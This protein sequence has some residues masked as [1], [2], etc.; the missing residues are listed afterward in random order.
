MDDNKIHPEDLMARDGIKLSDKEIEGVGDVYNNYYNWRSYRS[1]LIKHFQ[2]YSFEEY[3]IISREL[4]W[5]SI[6]TQSDDLSSLGLDFSLPFARK[7]V[8][9]FLGRINSLGIKPEIVGDAVDALGTKML[10]AIYKKWR[11][12]SNDKV[13]NFWEL[14]YGIVNGTVCSYIGYNNEEKQQR[15]L[16]S[17]DPESGNFSI[18]KKKIKK[19]EVF[20]EIIPI[21][22]IY[23]PKIF[24]RNIQ[25]QGRNIWKKQMDVSDFKEEFGKYP[26]SK[27]VFP[28]SRIAEDSLYFR[29]LGGTGTISA[30]KIEVIREFDWQKD[31]FKIT[32][33]GIVLNKLGKGEKFEWSPM[34]FSHKMAPFTWGIMGPL[35]E[36]LAYGL[37]TPFLIK[38]PHK[39]LNVS[40]SMMV[41]QEL[42][43]IDPPTLTS[44]IESPE[45]IFG[46]HKVIQVNDVNA[47]KVMESKEPSNQFFTMQNS[48]Q[49]LMSA[50]AQGG[51]A[52]TIPSRQPK[53]AREV[54]DI[55]QMKQ[56]AMA[57][58][59]TMYY[60][61]LRQRIMLVLKTSLQ[62]MS[63]AKFQTTD[64]RV[65]KDILVPDMPLT[66]G[67]TGNMRIRLVK[68]GSKQ[69]DMSLFI[70]AIKES[71]KN[72]K[73]T[74]IVEVPIEFIENLDFVI[75]RIDL[76]PEDS[77]DLEI[78]NFVANVLTPMIQTYIPAGVADIGKT[79]LRHM[80]KLGENPADYAKDQSAQS[81]PPQ[82]NNPF[83]Q[84]PGGQQGVPAV[85]GN[86][87]QSTTGIKFGSQN[88]QPLAAQ[89]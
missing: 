22:D 11:S 59:V 54:S 65:Y 16:N 20:K 33:S 50:H 39:I 62:F 47:Y 14:L 3:L 75:N 9:D 85:Q 80:E 64:K 67:G 71:A 82:Q 32:A 69:P 30:N 73:P 35:D 61:I 12:T 89:Q 68:N 21:E 60:D 78:A 63:S 31:T 26:L 58:A 83:Q 8:L 41:E 70:E 7:E 79:F 5:N 43:A 87:Q 74:E 10:Q 36:K 76:E 45:L 57:N 23:L 56:Q 24:E 55:N 1:G 28:G 42:R 19:D 17:Y 25:K 66:D 27:Y 86:M 48:L 2:N 53:S 29:L 84:Q 44:D 46:Q 18:I 34:P 72:G 77:S 81:A 38:A 6:T 88:S 52:E 13:E 15:F 37:S 49:G 40:Y 51:D 4:F